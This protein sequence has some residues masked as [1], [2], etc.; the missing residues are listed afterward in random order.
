MNSLRMVY[1]CCVEHLQAY[2]GRNFKATI[3]LLTM[4]LGEHAKRGKDA[5][6]FILRMEF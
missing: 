4:V 3:A 6:P 5:I 2:F 1:I